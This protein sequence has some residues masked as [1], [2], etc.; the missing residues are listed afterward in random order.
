MTGDAGQGYEQP[1]K[2]GVK[3]GK[4]RKWRNEGKGEQTMVREEEWKGEEKNTNAREGG[5]MEE[6]GGRRRGIKEYVERKGRM[7]KRQQRGKRYA[8]EGNAKMKICT[9]Y[10]QGHFSIHRNYSLCIHGST[11]VR[12]RESVCVCV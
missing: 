7:R 8:E 10:T 1:L 3:D 6:E 9:Y 5:R 2:L 11:S 12:M 4:G